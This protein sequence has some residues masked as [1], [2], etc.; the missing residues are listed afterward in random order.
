MIFGT[1][2]KELAG[3]VTKSTADADTV[4][5]IKKA[6]NYGKTQVSAYSHWRHLMVPNN[7]LLIIPQYVTGSAVVTQDSRTVTLAGGGVVSASF[8]GRYFK[9][10]KSQNPYEIVSVDTGLNTIT[11]KTAV[12]EESGTY[13]YSIVKVWY[14]VPSDCRIVMP[15]EEFDDLPVPFEINGYDDY[16]AG[17]SAAIAVTL[18]S[19][20]LTGAGFLDNVFPGDYITVEAN[21]YRVR[22]VQSDTR[23]ILANKAVKALSGTYAFS[24]DTPYKA[25]VK[26]FPLSYNGFVISGDSGKSILPFSYI[27]NLYDMVN[28]ADTSELPP[29]FDRAIMDFAKAEYKRATN[30]E[31]W[32][33]DLNLGQN[34]LQKL[35]LNRDLVWESHAQFNPLIQSGMGRGHYPRSRY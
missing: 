14:R 1:A 18:N 4:L 10:Q 16:Y 32:Q 30:T 23:I 28:D 22:Q 25:R 11:L 12:I 7:E 21:I 8:V 17:F 26:G 35:E 24:S 33:L 27:R 3:E 19:N 15:N 20:V 13:T 29:D 34:R 5:K 6:L 2:Q 9:G 31:G